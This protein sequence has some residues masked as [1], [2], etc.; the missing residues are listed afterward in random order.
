MRIEGVAYLPEP[1][2]SPETW[3][4]TDQPVPLRVE[5]NPM[6]NPIGMATLTKLDDGTIM[7]TA[8]IVEGEDRFLGSFPKFAIGVARTGGTWGGARVYSV[9]VAHENKNTDI[10]PYTVVKDPDDE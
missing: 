2:E 10:P 4:V 9:S 3:D 7:C 5:F 6:R 1:D 8:E